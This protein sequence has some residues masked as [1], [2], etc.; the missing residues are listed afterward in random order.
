M[1]KC[2]CKLQRLIHDTFTL[3]IVANFSITLERI[4]KIRNGKYIY[5]ISSRSKG[6]LFE[7][8]VPQNLHEIST[9]HIEQASD[10]HTIV[11]QN[12]AT[13]LIMVRIIP[14]R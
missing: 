12:T 11:G 1:P 6:S 8:G 13:V 5:K 3:L 10:M 7:V 9:S 4:I 2:L 14:K